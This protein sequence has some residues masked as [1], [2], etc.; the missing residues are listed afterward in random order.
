MTV[1]IYHLTEP[2]RRFP[3]DARLLFYR[4]TGVDVACHRTGLGVSL[5]GTVWTGS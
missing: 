5:G 2:R 4:N 3:G 1:T